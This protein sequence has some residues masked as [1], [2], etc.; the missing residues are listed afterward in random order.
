M[1]GR[2]RVDDA[3]RS[4]M[5]TIGEKLDDLVGLQSENENV[6]RADLIAYLDVRA[7][8]RA[9]GERA[10]QRQLHVAGA[11]GF[12]AGGRDLLAQLRS[13][14]DGLRERDAVIGQED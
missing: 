1:A 3:I 13:G 12:L 6:L 9:D 2:D 14:N 11:G 8:E 7:V 4:W 5:V 10:I